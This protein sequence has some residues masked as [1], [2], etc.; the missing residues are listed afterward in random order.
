MVSA[1]AELRNRRVARARRSAR[2]TGAASV[3]LSPNIVLLIVFTIGPVLASVA[4]SF[5]DW[6]VLSPPEFVGADNYVQLFGDAFFG[7][8]LRTTAVYAVFS[9]PLTLL[10]AL[11]MAYL[12]D[13]F[14]YFK[15]LF[16]VAL[17][18]PVIMSGV[19]I[20]LAW[21]R[22]FDGNYGIANYLLRFVGI[23]GPN[24]LNDPTWAVPSLIFITVWSSIG[25][26]T[27][28]FLAALAEVP[29]ELTQAAR[30]D[31]ASE[32]RIFLRIKLPMISPITFFALM[33]AT[34]AAFQVFDLVYVTT[35]GAAGTTVVI[36][37]IYDAAFG[38]FRMGFASSAAVIYLI[39]S[40]AVA[41]ALWL[42]RSRWVLG[43]DR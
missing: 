8:A 26:Y 22:F 5:T 38:S 16:R 28:F 33:N 3:L 2:D 37:Y 20:G 12:I 32:F 4:I 35:G 1:T 18:I 9:I 14:V 30:L 42:V 19:L 11:A 7:D 21:K 13:R 17:F 6:D 40:I 43:E 10:S 34:I 29:E 27:M 23:E 24:W 25:L 15:G 31:G 36:K 39:A 41:G